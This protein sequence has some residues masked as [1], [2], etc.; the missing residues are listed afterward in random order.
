MQKRKHGEDNECGETNN[1][2][3]ENDDESYAI[4][5]VKEDVERLAKEKHCIRPRITFLDFG[6]QSLY[7]AFHQ[8]YLSPKTYY[9]FVVDMTK[10]PDEKVHEP[11]MDEINCSRFKSWRYQ[12]NY[13]VTI[14][15]CFGKQ[16]AHAIIYPIC[17][18]IRFSV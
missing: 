10:R 13:T 6:G 16:D 8:I 12:G 11:G 5:K 14:Q 3:N 17:P 7:Y 15:T 2:E 1:Y 4:S 9:I 18:N